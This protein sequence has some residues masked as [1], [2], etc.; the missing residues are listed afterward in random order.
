M[1]WRHAGRVTCQ[2]SVSLLLHL[3]GHVDQRHTAIVAIGGAQSTGHHGGPHH[4]RMEDRLRGRRAHTEQEDRDEE[5]PQEGA[6]HEGSGRARER[7]QSQPL[8]DKEHTRGQEKSCED[9]TD[10]GNEVKGVE[11]CKKEDR[12]PVAKATR[13][14]LRQQ[15]RI[16]HECDH[17]VDSDGYNQPPGLPDYHAPYSEPFWI[18]EA[19]Q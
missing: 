12:C 4:T 13:G 8:R 7:N 15:S 16:Q 9:E 1:Q 5:G 10:P 18:Q 14:D 3:S 6:D 19:Y 11:H 17:V 2:L